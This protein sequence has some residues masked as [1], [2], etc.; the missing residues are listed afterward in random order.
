MKVFNWSIEHIAELNP[1]DID[2]KAA[3]QGHSVRYAY[4]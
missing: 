2:E 1:A 4:S 3:H